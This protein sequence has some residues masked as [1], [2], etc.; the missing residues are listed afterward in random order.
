MKE[1]VNLE[2]S[3]QVEVASKTEKNLEQAEQ[4]LNQVERQAEKEK[5]AEKG[6]L[7]SLKA[8]VFQDDNRNI[9]SSQSGQGQALPKSETRTA[10]EAILQ[11]DLVAAYQSMD[12]KAKIKF[13]A[14]GQEAA[15]K[16]EV[17]IETMKIKAKIVLGLIRNWLQL[18]PGVNKFFLEQESKLKTD[19]IVV[20]AKKRKKELKQKI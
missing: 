3:P 18:I 14:E 1:R 10:I 7:I 16:L 9:A 8:K 12:E 20:L 19:R 17:L 13:V 15:A 11:D 2:K 4:G 6:K 5:K